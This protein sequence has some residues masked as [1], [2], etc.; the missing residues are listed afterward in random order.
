MKMFVL[1]KIPIVKKV[2]CFLTGVVLV[3]SCQISLAKTG[4]SLSEN[5][6]FSTPVFLE[7]AD[8][9]VTGTVTDGLSGQ[10]MP[11]VAI[12]VK[13]SSNG[14]IT[15]RNGKFS[16]QVPD[17]SIL[18]FSYL[19]YETL[20]LNVNG[21]SLLDVQLQP[22]D[23]KIN[24]VI[25]IGYGTQRKTSSTAAVST[26]NTAEIAQKP[27]ANLTNS[28]V[29]R[30]SGLIVTQ[31]SGE[32]G[33]DAS[34]IQIRGAGTINRTSALTIVDGIPGD[35]SHLDPNTIATITILKDA[36]A[37]AVYGV[38][39]ANGVVLVTT[40]QGKPG[41]ATLS[42]N[43][44]VGF[45]NP[46]RL[47]VFVNSYQYALMRNEAAQND[48]LTSGQPLG[49]LFT[50]A[51]IQKYKDHSDPDAYGDGQPLKDIIKPNQLITYHNVTLTG[52]NED[53]KYF[54]SAGYT[55]QNG[56]WSSTYLNRYNGTLNLTANATKT[57]IVNLSVNAYVENQH[58][59]ATGAG[60]IL[61]QAM[62][63][64]PTV[65]PYYSNGLWSGYI[66]QSLVGEI[67]H[68]GYNV[69]ENS[70]LS[71][72]LSID[73]K[74]PVKGLSLKGIISYNN[75][76]DPIFGYQT[77]L[78]RN[79]STPIPFYNVVTSTTPY[80]FSTGTQGSQYPKF[81]ETYNQTHAITAQG[82]L[83][84]SRSFGKSDIT[85]LLAVDQRTVKF[86]T[87]TASRQ[88]YNLNI[89]ELDFGG[90]AAT[91][92]TNGGHSEG[93]KQIGYVYRFDYAYNKKYLFEATGRYD[94]SYLFAAKHQY[95]FFPAFSAGWRLSEEPF[96][97]ENL[98]WVDN[99]KI[100]GSFGQSGAYP[101]IG[102]GVA[103]YQYLSPYKIYGNAGVI[104]NNTTQGVYE[105]LQG[106]PAITWEKA[107]KS[108]IGF[109]GSF[110]N[111][112]LGVEADYFFEKRSNL[113][114]VPSSATPPEYGVGLG[115]VNGGIM[116]N[117]G[118][119]IT[120]TSYKA[121][122]KDLRLDVKGTFTFA[123]NKILNFFEQQ[124]TYTNP[125]TRQTG[126]PNG[127]QFGLIAQGY[128]GATDFNADGTLKAGL[129][130][131]TFGPVYPGDLKYQDLSGPNG[132]PDGK[133]DNNDRTAIGH[134]NTP[135]M[136]FGI[137][138]RLNYKNFDLD[139]L[140]QGSG[141]SNIQLNN[142]FVWPFQASGSA[143][144]LSY[145]DHWTPSNPTALY[146]R[147]YGTPHA[148]NTQQSTWWQRDNSYIRLR[149]FELGYSF[150]NKVLHNGI[151][152]LR[153]YVAGNNVL[154]WTK[155]FKETLDP[156]NSGSNENYFQQRVFSVGI[157]ATF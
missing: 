138:P 124:G 67:Y 77:Q 109:E 55:H 36:A 9:T 133:I 118:V 150:S 29:G 135:E 75:G 88:N 24:E 122:S 132:K 140:F 148:N 78:I 35:F 96:I 48:H 89:D 70:S 85:A 72:Q 44:Y 58:F 145:T 146:P 141:N 142:Y 56:M 134:P 123:R 101:S 45:Q 54:A 3:F 11:G 4:I 90:P 115:E 147:L 34:N 21:K 20:T 49:Q 52:G 83:N 42:Y 94:G 6:K 31:G 108:D 157:N 130:V 27:V 61:D 105:A 114:V 111:G 156:E 12:T 73:Q 155:S 64:N 59:P 125:N 154:T 128:Y 103:T 80:T 22:T 62:R 32:P 39:G 126:R 16:L 95:G 7:K 51:E 47:P 71:T 26:I 117:Q 14:V 129:P 37:V 120:L 63:Q 100:R 92:A 144:E 81:S 50:P 13:S 76:P 43:G 84:Y 30:A 86:Q 139:L 57:T 93:Q 98:L 33:F 25:V 131:P 119:D 143:T 18:V 79:Y 1:N 46:T 66:G 112:L 149:S 151:R 110:W 137:E 153:I 107:N 65:P 97:K 23:K 15:D 91:D 2:F 87:L 104:G 106:N 113:L 69:N 99:L 10:P 41:K 127:T 8:R 5:V 102:G 74:L 60:S 40:K 68:S 116:Q 38:A 19:G 152:A 82:L 136:I 28:L 17:N 121:F 53:I